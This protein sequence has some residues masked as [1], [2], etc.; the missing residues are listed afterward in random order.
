MHSDFE[1]QIVIV[2]NDDERLQ[3]I[4][5]VGEDTLPEEYGGRAKLRVLQDV[6]LAPLDN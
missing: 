1:M 5:E 4:K 3:F 6:Q 2:T